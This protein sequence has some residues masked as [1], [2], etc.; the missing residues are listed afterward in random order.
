MSEG[1]KKGN[2]KLVKSNHPAHEIPKDFAK[3]VSLLICFVLNFLF[4]ISN[5]MFVA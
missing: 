3:E 5:F 2:K 4:N 1:P